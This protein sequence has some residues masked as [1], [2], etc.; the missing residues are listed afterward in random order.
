[1]GRSRGAV[2]EVDPG[3]GDERRE[4]ENVNVDDQSSSEDEGGDRSAPETIKQAR[5][6]KQKDKALDY[7]TL[8]QEAA[9]DAMVR[10]LEGREYRFELKRANGTNGTRTV[11]CSPRSRTAYGDGNL[12]RSEHVFRDIVDVAYTLRNPLERLLQES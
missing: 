3:A 1:M 7:G 4:D 9:K 6:R 11:V 5:R 8:E 10:D 12:Y 2:G